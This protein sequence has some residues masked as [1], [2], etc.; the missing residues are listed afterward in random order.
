MTNA[1]LAIATDTVCVTV[2]VHDN[3]FCRT[4][5]FQI[6]KQKWSYMSKATMSFKQQRTSRH[7]MLVVSDYMH[8]SE[9][10]QYD[11]V[12]QHKF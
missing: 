12:F 10:G 2:E 11:K 1:T 5:S 3:T 6:A 4:I 8:N 9:I 7:K